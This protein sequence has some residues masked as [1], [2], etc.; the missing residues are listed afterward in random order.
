MYLTS[1]SRSRPGIV[2][3][4]DCGGTCQGTCTGCEAQCRGCQG[5]CIGGAKAQAT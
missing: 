2:V 1:K 3:T 4:M 5:G